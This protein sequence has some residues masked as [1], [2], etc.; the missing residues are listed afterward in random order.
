MNFIAELLDAP[1]KVNL[2]SL[3]KKIGIKI[4]LRQIAIVYG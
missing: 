1:V 3:R 4:V 2:V